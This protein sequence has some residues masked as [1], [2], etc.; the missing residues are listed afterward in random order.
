MD[1]E[2][3]LQVYM[4]ISNQ[5]SRGWRWQELGDVCVQY[6]IIYFPVMIYY[7]K[8]QILS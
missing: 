3:T 6:E 5:M 4:Q 1:R 8:V 2:E 7:Y